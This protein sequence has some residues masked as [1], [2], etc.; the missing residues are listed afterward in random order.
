MK[1]LHNAQ[2]AIQQAIEAG[3]DFEH[4]EHDGLK[5]PLT[6]MR[7]E[8]KIYSEF[9]DG[10]FPQLMVSAIYKDS[11]GKEYASWVV[12]ENL[13]RNRKNDFFIDPLLWRALGKARGWTGVTVGNNIIGYQNSWQR[14]ATVWFEIRLSN[15]DETEFWQSLP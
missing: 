4:A 1:Q 6:F 5:P 10:R 12:L 3:F 14:Y 2:D 13:I 9:T 8:F 11:K 15:G 7:N